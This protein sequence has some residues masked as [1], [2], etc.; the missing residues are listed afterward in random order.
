MYLTIIDL[1]NNPPPAITKITTINLKN[2]APNTLKNNPTPMQMP[3]T[4][5]KLIPVFKYQGTMSVLSQAVKHLLLNY[6]TIF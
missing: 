3:A 5:I 4:A 6:F 2:L 1:T